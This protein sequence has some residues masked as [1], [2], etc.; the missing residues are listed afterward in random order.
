[1]RTITE[2]KQW[3]NDQDIELTEEQIETV[4]DSLDEIEEIEQEMS[5]EEY[6]EILDDLYPEVRIGCCTF[7]PSQIL[8]E[9]DPIAYNCGK[10]DIFEAKT[11]Y[12]FND[13]E[14]DD[15]DEA[16]TELVNYCI[17]DQP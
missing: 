3:L 14:Y 4:F 2:L 15:Y 8:K 9:L 12:E 5:D 10:D 13:V 11:V 16:L 6:D 17:D 1:M 7:S